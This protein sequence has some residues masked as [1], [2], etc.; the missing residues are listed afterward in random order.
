MCDLMDSS[1]DHMSRQDL[2]DISGHCPILSTNVRKNPTKSKIVQFCPK[3]IPGYLEFVKIIWHHGISA[4]TGC[5]WACFLT[6]IRNMDTKGLPISCRCHMWC[7]ALLPACTKSLSFF[8]LL[9]C[10]C[11]IFHYKSLFGIL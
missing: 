1:S 8:P 2:L 11:G 9:P 4:C 5:P 3:N 6:C 10:I 7:I